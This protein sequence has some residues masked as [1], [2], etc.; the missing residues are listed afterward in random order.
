[1]YVERPLTL[2]GPPGSATG[3]LFGRLA[4]GLAGALIWTS[5]PEPDPSPTDQ[6][7]LPDGCMDLIWLNDQLVVAGPDTEPW[8]G[9]VAGFATATGAVAG[10]QPI[11]GV[12]FPSGV[13]PS[14]LGAP[15]AEL[16]NRRVPLAELW[17]RTEVRRWEDR[18]RR[19]G[20]S[21]VLTEL[22]TLRLAEAEPVHPIRQ[23]ALCCAQARPVSEIVAA[24]GWS[25]RTLHRHCLAGFGYG[26]KTLT[27]VLRF[28]RATALIGAGTSLVDAAARCGYADQPH[29]SREV[30]EFAGRSPATFAP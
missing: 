3:A 29:L 7:V 19:Q 18:A 15:A 4:E 12:R 20:A 21:P 27:R 14:V 17:R 26:A 8:L 1:M 9:A 10:P 2:P 28:R 25:E 5:E 30:K 6:V 22:S 23:V 24:T 16:R 11:T 13:A